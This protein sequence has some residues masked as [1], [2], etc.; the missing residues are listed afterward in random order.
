MNQTIRHIEWTLVGLDQSGSRCNDNDRVP[1]T[2]QSSR[3]LTYWTVT[4]LLANSSHAITFTL[5]LMRFGKGI[6]STL[7]PSNYGFN[8]TTTVL[9]QG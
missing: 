8:S 3:T 2:S 1:H 5:G 4:S 9:L 6:I 7:Y